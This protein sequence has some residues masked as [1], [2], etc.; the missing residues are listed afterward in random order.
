MM[1]FPGKFFPQDL[2]VPSLT[3]Y[4]TC[5]ASSSTARG[6]GQPG[7]TSEGTQEEPVP[8]SNPFYGLE[9]HL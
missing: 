8:I 3:L 9:I 6:M 4:L 5:A 1:Q 2:P 7:P